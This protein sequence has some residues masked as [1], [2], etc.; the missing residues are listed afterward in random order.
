MLGAQL[1]FV[2]FLAAGICAAFWY[3]RALALLPLWSEFAGAEEPMMIESSLGTSCN[4]LAVVRLHPH[5][6]PFASFLIPPAPLTKGG[7]Y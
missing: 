3:S 2:A 5:S 4:A 1:G 7:N 6:L